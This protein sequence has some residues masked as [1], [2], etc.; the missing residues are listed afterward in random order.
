M[1]L[2]DLDQGEV[3]GPPQL[4]RVV[5]RGGDEEGGVGAELAAQRVPGHRWVH[6]TYSDL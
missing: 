2:V 1:R 6:R 5:G 4:G 3:G